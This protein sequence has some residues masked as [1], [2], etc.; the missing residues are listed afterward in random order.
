MIFNF[1]YF[2]IIQTQNKRPSNI[3]KTS[4]QSYQTQIIIILAYEN[5]WVSL[6][7]LWTTW[8]RSSTFRLVLIYFHLTGSNWWRSFEK[9][10]S[11]E[12]SLFVLGFSNHREATC[13]LLCAND[14]NCWL[15]E[16]RLWGMWSWNHTLWILILISNNLCTFGLV[17]LPEYT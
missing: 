9:N 15:L 3:Q 17:N 16:S 13:C 14:K 5:S 2:E 6:I 8:P 12:T 7:R 10:S 1:V 4:L 11:G